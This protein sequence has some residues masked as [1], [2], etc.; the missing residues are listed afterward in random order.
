MV[1]DSHS[2]GVP[3]GICGELAGDPSAA[4][5]LMAMGFDSLSMSA[6]NLLRVKSVIRGVK[7]ADAQAL[8]AE[9]KQLPDT[10]SINRLIHRVYN[11]A[12]S[13]GLPSRICLGRQNPIDACPALLFTAALGLNSIP[14]LRSI[15]APRF[16][17]Q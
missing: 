15:A 2:Q 17:C 13:L 9:V 11:E 8:L 4:L 10:E 14:P 12:G 5:L 7:F 16:V 1:E 6:T 3:V